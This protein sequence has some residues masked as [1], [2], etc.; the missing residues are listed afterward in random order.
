MTQVLTKNNI[1]KNFR[2][3]IIEAIQEI[4]RDP[5]LDLEL[6]P[7]AKVRLRKER[8]ILSYRNIPLSE[9]KRRHL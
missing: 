2:A 7:K 8:K 1:Q 6:S 4:L 9:I 3:L 5:D